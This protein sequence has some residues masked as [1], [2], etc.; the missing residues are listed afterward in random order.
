MRKF[1]HEFIYNT[2]RPDSPAHK[3][4]RSVV[5]VA[6]DEVICVKCS[7]AV[8]ANTTGH[9]GDMIDVGLG[10][11]GCHGSCDVSF[12]K[13]IF[14]V[15]IPDGFEIEVGAIE[16]WFEELEAACMR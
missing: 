12:S 2:I 1:E 7:Q 11:H 16:K 8:L 14:A 6:K 9:G 5:R 4:Q 3:V 13:F 10:D 15:L